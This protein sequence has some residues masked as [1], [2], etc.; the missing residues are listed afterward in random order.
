ML[1][2]CCLL[3]DQAHPGDVQLA[4][5]YYA[6][7]RLLIQWKVG[8]CKKVWT[9]FV[10]DGGNLGGRIEWK[11]MPPKRANLF[12]PPPSGPSPWHNLQCIFHFAVSKSH[13]VHQHGQLQTCS[14]L[15]IMKYEDHRISI[16]LGPDMMLASPMKRTRALLELQNR[17]RHR[18]YISNLSSHLLS[19]LRM[20]FSCV[21][22]FLSMVLD[23]MWRAVWNPLCR[24][25]RGNL[26]VAGF[27][28]L[29]RPK[30]PINIV[31]FH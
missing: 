24:W 27:S 8:L 18:V 26:H 9:L 19:L 29:S 20:M 5:Y 7:R 23:A 30:V 6:T 25:E 11:L 3:V 4:T 12:L 15:W 1:H 22:P 28:V 13:S 10:S 31:T 2:H 17:G 21:G 14:C 16:T